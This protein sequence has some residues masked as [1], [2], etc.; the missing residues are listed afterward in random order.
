MGKKYIIQATVTRGNVSVQLPT[1]FL[2][3]NIHGITSPEWAKVVGEHLCYL[4][5][6]DCIPHVFAMEEMDD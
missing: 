4:I 6:P 1:F 5:N 2:D 3:V